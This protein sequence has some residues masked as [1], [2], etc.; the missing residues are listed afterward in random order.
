MGSCIPQSNVA[1]PAG[2]AEF[3]GAVKQVSET[4]GFH[5]LLNDIFQRILRMEL[6]T[7]SSA[8]SF[9][10]GRM[11]DSRCHR[12]TAAADRTKFPRPLQCVRVVCDLECHGGDRSD[13]R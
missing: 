1:F 8:V 13:Q 2:E 12:G 11:L 3:I 4:I 7:A 5:D 9:S 10:V 6:R